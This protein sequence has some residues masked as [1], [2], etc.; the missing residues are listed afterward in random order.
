MIHDFSSR[1][2]YDDGANVLRNFTFNQKKTK[3]AHVSTPLCNLTGSLTWFK[4]FKLLT[5]AT[6]FLFIIINSATGKFFDLFGV[7]RI[8]IIFY[9]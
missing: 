4:C 1:F 9:C 7:E 3:I 6:A 5:S 2:S 8:S